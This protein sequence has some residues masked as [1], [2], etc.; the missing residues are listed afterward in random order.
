MYS[1]RIRFTPALLILIILGSAFRMSGYFSS[2]PVSARAT[3][4][5]NVYLPIIFN[6][7]QLGPALISGVAYDATIGKEN[8]ALPG[9]QVCIQNTTNCDTSE[10]DGGYSLG[11][12]TSG[13]QTV[14]ATRNGY[15]TLV[16]Q[17]TAIAYNGTPQSI[18]T[19]DLALS[20]NDLSENQYRI[21]LTWGGPNIQAADLDA[22]LW[23]PA[24]TPYYVNQIS[25]TNAGTGNCGAFP[26][27]CLDIDSQD[28]LQ[29]ET[30]RITQAHPGTY[31]YAVKHYDI[32]AG[33]YNKPSLSQTN[34]HVDVYDANGLIASFDVPPSSD[35]AAVYWHVF[36]LDAVN[37]Q[38]TPVN[39]IG[40]DPS[41]Y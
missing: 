1:P 20:K 35:N 30:I 34:A 3:V 11:G 32:G 22:N 14:V 18:T 19:L 26:H 31:V 8:G 6:N 38:L 41:P 21:V 5:T 25:G 28:G 37:G 16:R 33:N 4:N 17:V 36:D 9:V 7:F 23:L 40:G 12:I 29:P 2:T 15:S 13:P 10:A 24:A 39:I 27:A